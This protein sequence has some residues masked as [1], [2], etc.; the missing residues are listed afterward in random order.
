MVRPHR[1]LA[2]LAS[3]VAGAAL[4]APAAPA[5]QR[6]DAV[7]QPA[8]DVGPTGATLN[9]TVTPDGRETRYAFVYGTTRYDAHTPVAS[10][11]GDDDPV[12]VRARV[13]GLTPQTTYHVRLIAFSRHRFARGAD[14]TFTTAAPPPP[15][16]PPVPVQPAPPPPATTLAPAGPPVFA[17]SVGVTERSG[18]VRVKPPGA[19]A[20]LAL[21]GAA[22]IPVGSLV[23]TRAGSVTLRSALPSGATQTGVFHG[24]LFDVGQTATGVTELVLR[25][26]MPACGRA[27]AAATRKRKP[28][29][30]RLW[31]R[32]EHGNFRTRGGSSVATV[33]GTAWYVEDRCNGTLTRVS[34]GRVSVYDRGRRISVVVRAGHSY[35]ARARR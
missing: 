32:D 10:A 8:T 28:P 31:G 24:G 21:S 7:T 17:Q 20:Y 6:P 15:L 9:G 25:G 16:P 29:R 34:A 22:S 18:A 1:L 4:A 5:H 14:V 33:R 23:D 3:V 35:L 11:G 27:R 13:E 26:A 30:R 2:L 19:A 12:A